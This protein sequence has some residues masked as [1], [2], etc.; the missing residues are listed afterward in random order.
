MK[1]VNV[2]NVAK[3]AVLATVAAALALGLSSPADAAAGTMYG[4]PAAAAKWWRHQQ[5]DDCAIMSSADVIGQLTGKEPS[6]RAIVKKA[7]ST[8]VD[9]ARTGRRS[10]WGSS[11]RSEKTK[12][13]TSVAKP[14]IAISSVGGDCSMMTGRWH[15]RP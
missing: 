1:T 6:E 2:A 4:D 11:S 5:F 12:C 9:A 10:A 15:A 14:V 13:G 3:T 8:L 7:Q